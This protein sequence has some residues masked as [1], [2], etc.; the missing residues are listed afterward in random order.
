MKLSKVNSRRKE[1]NGLLGKLISQ[2]N[3]Y[4]NNASLQY[5]R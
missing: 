1:N 3:I 5:I 2:L 4:V